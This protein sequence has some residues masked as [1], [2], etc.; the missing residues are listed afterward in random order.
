MDVTNNRPAGFDYLRLC[1]SLF[2]AVWHIPQIAYGDAG[3]GFWYN[4][5]I[6]EV[7]RFVLPMFFALSGFLVAGSLDR[8]LTL[9]AF[10][11]L[12]VIRIFPALS[13]EVLLS[14]LI[15]GPLV[16]TVPLS[17][18]FSSGEFWRYLLNVTGEIHYT[19]PG[20]FKNAVAGNLVN[21]QLWT[22]PYELLC[23]IAL[24]LLALVGARNSRALFL[25]SALSM[26]FVLV[27]WG[28]THHWGAQ[29]Y[30]G[31]GTGLGHG[32]GLVNCFV[33]GV[34][35]F[36][37]KKLLPWS[38]ALFIL[39]FAISCALLFTESPLSTFASIPVAYCTVFLG[40]T[41]PKRIFVLASAD[42]SYGIYLYHWPVFQF[43]GYNLGNSL[44]AII[45]IGLPL[46]VAFAAFSWHVIEKPALEFR[47]PIM[48]QDRVGGGFAL[49]AST[50]FC[51]A[52]LTFVVCWKLI[53][54]IGY[55]VFL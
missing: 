19:L 36:F 29:M 27:A 46:L 26:P 28:L 18:Y 2:V 34:M 35:I 17:Q 14:A 12:R 37:F 43:I 20:V 3:L 51:A 49:T 11:G 45:L 7:S 8:C 16:T 15:L 22:V 41:N 39:M 32:L 55:S 30:A 31:V 33:A 47:K 50:V 25:L 42:Y 48:R 44:V 9:S 38:I 10:L 6:W 21:A 52:L 13:V 23:Y 54:R 5:H 24:S 40:L 53:E 1:L 4:N